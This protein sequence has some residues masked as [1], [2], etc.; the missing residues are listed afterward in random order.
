MS[1]SHNLA[2]SDDDLLCSENGEDGGDDSAEDTLSSAESGGSGD[3]DNAEDTACSL[4]PP[5]IRLRAK[6]VGRW[7]DTFYVATFGVVQ[8]KN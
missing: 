4:R 5:I 7:Y 1:A 8:Y 6:N 2:L 3:K